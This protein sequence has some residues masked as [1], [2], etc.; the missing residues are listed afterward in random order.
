MTIAQ[1]IRSS[2]ALAALLAA[3]H[4][5]A[6]QSRPAASAFDQFKSLVGEWMDADGAAGPKGKVLATYHLTGG[7]SAVVET[8]FPGAPHEMTTIFHRDGNDMVLTHY[9]SGG[10]QPRMRAREVNGN[11]IAFEFDG[12]TNMN[13]A[14]DGH[15]HDAVITFLGP[16]E[17]RAHWKAWDKGKPSAHSPNFRLQRKKG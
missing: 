5:G 8:L 9:C 6:Q 3:A 13:P 14:Q 15:M 4:A 12:G 2:I 16:D 1:T 17:I 10:N 11:T 7:G